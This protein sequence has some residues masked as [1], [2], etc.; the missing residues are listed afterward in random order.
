MSIKEAAHEIV[1]GLADD[2]TWNDLVRALY[3]Q[4]KITLGMSDLEIV[5]PELSDAEISTVMARIQ[6]SS[7]QPDDMRNTRS[8]K[9]GNAAT[10]GMVAGVIAVLF[11][12]VFPPVS[13]VAVPVAIVAGFIGIK[14]KEEK[15]WVPVLLGLVSIIPFIEL[16]IETSK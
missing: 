13:W 14:R 9:P 12:L 2:A 8:Y 4:K 6:S 5:K 11:A 15:A 3:K 16:L 1:D 10:I 7:S